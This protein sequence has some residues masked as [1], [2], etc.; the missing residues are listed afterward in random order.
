MSCYYKTDIKKVHS[1]CFPHNLRALIIGQSG[2]GKT[3]LLMRLLLEDDLLNY[4]KLYIYAKS[5]Y[6]PE[7]RVLKAGLKQGFQK[8]QIK[9][10]MKIDKYLKNNDYSLE[11]LDLIFEGLAERNKLPPFCLD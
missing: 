7:Y 8:S 9:S 11:D 3:A 10:L 2:A 5:L 6:Q 1:D 4:D